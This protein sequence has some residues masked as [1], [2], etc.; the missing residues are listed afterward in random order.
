MD[1][2]FRDQSVS[3]WRNTFDLPVEQLCYVSGLMGA[4]SQLGAIMC[5]K[6]P[7]TDPSERSSATAR[8]NFSS[9]SRFCI[10]RWYN[11]NDFLEVCAGFKQPLR[12][13]TM[14]ETRCPSTHRLKSAEPS[15]LHAELAARSLRS[16]HDQGMGVGHVPV[17]VVPK[18]LER[19]FDA[20]LTAV[21][22][23]LRNS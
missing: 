3:S 12:S 2:P 16:L 21:M 9:P 14:T 15:S 7:V 13:M 6:I 1:S 19:V 23:D 17:D 5:P 10:S 20:K 8:A 4:R 22:R 18:E 11:A